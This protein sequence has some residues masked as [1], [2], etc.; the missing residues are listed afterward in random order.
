MRVQEIANNSRLLKHEIHGTECL[1]TEGKEEVE[2][3][4]WRTR[5]LRAYS[6]VE[7]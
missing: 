2:A 7:C 4:T 1:E 5:C 6:L 3:K